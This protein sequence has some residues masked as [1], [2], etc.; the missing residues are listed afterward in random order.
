MYVYDDRSA[1]ALVEYERNFENERPKMERDS[2][3]GS[4]IKKPS[5]NSHRG[6]FIG[7]DSK[8]AVEI[9]EKSQTPN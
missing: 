5:I 3:K 6:T 8:N 4:H 9:I 2:I 1:N 7:V